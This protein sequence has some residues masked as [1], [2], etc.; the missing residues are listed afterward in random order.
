MA[1]VRTTIRPYET[2]EVTA[3]ERL[4]LQRQGLLLTEDSVLYANFYMYTG[5]PPADVTGISV[6][7][8]KDAVTLVNADTNISHV[9]TGAYAYQWSENDR[10]GAG[11]YTVTWNATDA[12]SLPVTAVETVTLDA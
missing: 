12:A 2:I 5:G 1:L 10:D 6:T 4:D 3:K 8:E 11:D 9:A 7:I